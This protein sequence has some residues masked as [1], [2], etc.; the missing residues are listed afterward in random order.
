MKWIHVDSN[1]LNKGTINSPKQ[2]P[3]RDYHGE[4]T[5]MCAR[6]GWAKMFCFAHERGD[7]RIKKQHFWVLL[8]VWRY[9]VY[10]THFY[11]P[12][13]LAFTLPQA[14]FC[15]SYLFFFLSAVWVQDDHRPKNVVKW[16]Q[17]AFTSAV[18]LFKIEFE[19]KLGQAI[20]DV[21]RVW[22]FFVCVWS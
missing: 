8:Y 6:S 12:S 21:V 2:F 15:I 14:V 18:T 7:R 3:V 11:T 16:P 5:E 22:L 4:K 10:P 9:P 1:I 20:F 13:C 19:H 17:H